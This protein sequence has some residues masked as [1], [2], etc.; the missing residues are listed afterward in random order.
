VSKAV[1]CIETDK[2]KGMLSALHY[3]SR[4][5]RGVHAHQAGSSSVPYGGDDNDGGDDNS[6]DDNGGDALTDIGKV[7]GRREEEEDSN[8]SGLLLAGFESGAVTSF[9][10]RTH[11]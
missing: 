3:N 5:A 7:T 8:C 9:D 1:G 10:L 11:R 2:S 4:V 6:D